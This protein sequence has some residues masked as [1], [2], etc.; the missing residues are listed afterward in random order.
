MPDVVIVNPFD[1]RAIR[2]EL[3]SEVVYDKAYARDGDYLI[4]FDALSLASA[5]GQRIK[6]IA[7]R[8]C[9]FGSFYMLQ[10]DTWEL[11]SLGGAPRILPGSVGGM[12]QSFI[13]DHDGDSVEVRV[14]AYA[15]LGCHA[16]GYNGRGKF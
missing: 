16:P 8:N 9:E 6:I 14:A 2:S 15:Q 1:H 7:D 12:G 5:S 11:S 13:W 10:L 3:G 4:G